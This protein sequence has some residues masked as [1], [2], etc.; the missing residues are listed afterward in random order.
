M[1]TKNRARLYALLFGLGLTA[2]GGLIGYVLI[3]PE[4]YQTDSGAIQTYIQGNSKDNYVS[5]FQFAN[6]AK[7]Y[8][9]NEPNF[10]GFSINSLGDGNVSLH[11]LQSSETDVNVTATDG[12][13]LKG[14]GYDVY[15]I[16]V[17][18]TQTSYQTTRYLDSPTGYIS[19]YRTL[20][21]LLIGWGVIT[22]VLGL[23]F[24]LT[25]LVTFLCA[26][27]GFIIPGVLFFLYVGFFAGTGL[28]W[29]SWKQALEDDFVTMLILG[30]IGW[31]IGI[32]VGIVM[33]AQKD[34]SI[35]EGL[36]E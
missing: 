9:I 35:A 28:D 31:V 33:L 2:L 32:I 11:Y 13:G 10:S 8:R 1:S 29:N 27:A 17:I 18:S 5:Y 26:G 16:S 23:I 21:Q 7:V 22:A 3:R 30:A 36:I 24:P 4:A 15:E 20:C 19:D 25:S 34:Y 6:S 12:K 14:K